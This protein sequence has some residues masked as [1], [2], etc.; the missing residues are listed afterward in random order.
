MQTQNIFK[1]CISIPIIISCTTIRFKQEC[2]TNFKIIKSNAQYISVDNI[3]ATDEYI[4]IEFTNTSDEIVKI[5]WQHTNLNS[6]NIV[7][8]KNDTKLTNNLKIYKNKY[9]ELLI[10]PKT[11]QTFKI[12][13]LG[14][15]EQN[16]KIAINNSKTQKH[17]FNKI[18]YPATLKLS[19]TKPNINPKQTIDIVISRIP[20][21]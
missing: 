21:I 3:E 17:I 11:S 20:K 14:Q 15:P 1:I 10:G 5:N 8:K 6:K 9:K 16:T 18:K 19:I 12:Y 13:L 4:Y 2:K 7:T